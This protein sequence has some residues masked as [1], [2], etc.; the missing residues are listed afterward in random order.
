LNPEDGEEDA[1][2]DRHREANIAAWGLD[3]N[4]AG[5]NDNFV[6]NAANVVMSA[7][8]DAAMG[9]RGDR[10]SG[11]RRRPRQTTQGSADAGLVPNFLGDESVL[12]VAPAARRFR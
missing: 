11:R 2:R 3:N 1:P 6:S 4:E 9:R 5:L 8:G 7:F 10:E 12:G